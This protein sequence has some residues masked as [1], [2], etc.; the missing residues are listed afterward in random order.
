M[1]EF[2]HFFF[3]PKLFCTIWANSL[4]ASFCLL[5]SLIFHESRNTNYSCLNNINNDYLCTKYL[6]LIRVIKLKC[7]QKVRLR[8]THSYKSCYIHNL[9]HTFFFYSAYLN[10]T[11]TKSHNIILRFEKVWY[12]T[13]VVYVCYELPNNYSVL[14]WRLLCIKNV[15]TYVYMNVKMYIYENKNKT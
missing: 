3:I 2:H 5:V 14:F 12:C 13:Y 7:G 8:K 11:P 15:C 9:L 6:I 1:C 10:F 4:R